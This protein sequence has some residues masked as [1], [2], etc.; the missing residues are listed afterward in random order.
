MKPLLGPDG[1][2]PGAT[3]LDLGAG[4]GAPADLGLVPGLGPLDARLPAGLLML[5]LRPSLGEDSYLTPAGE[6]VRRQV[7]RVALPAV[8]VGGEVVAELHVVHDCLEGARRPPGQSGQAVGELL[9]GH[10]AQSLILVAVPEV[11]H[12]RVG[13]RNT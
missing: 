7:V 1:P 11:V 4:G 9:A 5:P 2:G 12:D 8:A 10:P 13:V 6:A 3:V